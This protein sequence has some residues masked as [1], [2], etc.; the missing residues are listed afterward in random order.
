[1]VLRAQVIKYIQETVF[2]NNNNNNSVRFFIYLRAEL[3][4]QWPI[5]ESA[6]SI[7]QNKKHIKRQK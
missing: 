2:Y 5:T 1:M 6:R 3:K 4:S 7:K